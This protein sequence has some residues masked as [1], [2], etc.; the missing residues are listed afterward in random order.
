MCSPGVM[1]KMNGSLFKGLTCDCRHSCWMYVSLSFSWEKAVGQQKTGPLVCSMSH[2]SKRLA[3]LWKTLLSK[4]LRRC[5]GCPVSLRVHCMCHLS[6]VKLLNGPVQDNHVDIG[7]VGWMQ[8][9]LLRTLRSVWHRAYIWWCRMYCSTWCSWNM[10]YCVLCC[11][12]YVWYHIMM[13]LGTP[14]DLVSLWCSM[15]ASLIS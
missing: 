6:L 10:C 3:L 12:F 7:S 4:G 14:G 11:K 9:F 15:H 13:T 1:P 8:W 2:T 5:V